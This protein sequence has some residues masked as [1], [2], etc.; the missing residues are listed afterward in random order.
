[1]ERHIKLQMSAPVQN[2]WP[3]LFQNAS[4]MED[5]EKLIKNSRLRNQIAVTTA[6]CV[7]LDQTTD[8]IL[9]RTIN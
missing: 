2:S 4:F 6:Q 8:K 3:V 1:M 7:I 9:I 5:K